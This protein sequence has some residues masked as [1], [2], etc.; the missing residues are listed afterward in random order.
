MVAFICTATP[1]AQT[2]PSRVCLAEGII[3]GD[4]HVPLILDPIGLLLE[5]LH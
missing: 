5:H 2:S 4:E 1:E 3:E